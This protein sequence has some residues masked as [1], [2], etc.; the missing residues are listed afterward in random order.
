MPDQTG[1]EYRD[2]GLG[3]L[4]NNWVIGDRVLD[5]AYRWLS[6]RRRDSSP[7]NDVWTPETAL[8]VGLIGDW[9]MS[10]WILA[11]SWK[12]CVVFLLASAGYLWETKTAVALTAGT[13]CASS[14]D[15]NNL[16]VAGFD[17]VG[18]QAL[19]NGA[20][21]NQ[22]G[23]LINNAN[24]ASG[25]VILR[26]IL[27]SFN[28]GTPGDTNNFRIG[29]QASVTNVIVAG[30]ATYV[31]GANLVIAAATMI[32]VQYDFGGNTLNFTVTVDPVAHTL[33]AFTVQAGAL[34]GAGP[35]ESD[36]LDSQQ[37]SLTPL[38]VNNQ[39]YDLI[40][41]VGSNLDGQFNG[42]GMAPV[43][44]P[45]GF[46]MS[47]TGTAK[48]LASR[49]RELR[50]KHGGRAFDLFAERL[51]SEDS[52]HTPST[53]ALDE[54]TNAGGGASTGQIAALEAQSPDQRMDISALGGEQTYGADIDPSMGE[55]AFM[56]SPWNMW[57]KGTW[58]FYDGDGSSFDGTIA[59][60]VGGVD[61]RLR[62]DL[63]VGV[64]GGYGLARFDTLTGGVVGSFDAD[65]LSVGGYFGWMITPD[66]MMD[67]LIAY[68]A[69][70]YDN[71]SGATTGSFD[72][73]RITV[74]AHLKGHTDLGMV[75]MEP[76][77]GLMYA[78][79]D[80]S[81]YTD[82]AAVLHAART[83][84]AG[85]VSVGPKFIWPEMITDHG[86]TQFW[87]AAKG[88]Y[89]FSN[90]ASSATS[91]LPDIDDVA[92]A[93][94]Q[95]GITSTNDSGV[96]LS[97]QGDLSGLGSGEFIAYGGTAKVSVPF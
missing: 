33:S 3:K 38:I 43:V 85:R 23:G 49:N 74:A 50:A 31:S 64:L 17:T 13:M 48:W 67:G 44:S 47:S 54:G 83:V 7:H 5:E 2:W 89:D 75:V 12:L 32:T 37:S 86:M 71:T 15:N 35:S 65:G 8:S 39:S 57:V 73:D 45:N 59:N 90:Q 6:Q 21:L 26:V 27:N 78:S 18:T 97:L 28:D 84:T 92:S 22:D 55:D 29:F 36:N 58:T 52:S 91:G 62:E 94:V 41:G 72:A 46:A 87:F 24:V 34:P 66:L 93:R 79:E 81:A 1:V 40:N 80:Q 4:S 30:D 9:K 69:S 16:D 51:G 19:Q 42:N 88:E 61:Y 96:T 11:L 20:C 60:V 70:D 68:T 10:R 63:I 14:T 25:S 95:A 82:S 53:A 77:I 56:P 76:T